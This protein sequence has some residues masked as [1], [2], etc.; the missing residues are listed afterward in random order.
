MNYSF[1]ELLVW[2]LTFN[3]SEI[4]IKMVKQSNLWSWT[5]ELYSLSI[6]KLPLGFSFE[7]KTFFV[8][9]NVSHTDVLSLY[10]TT[11]ANWCVERYIWVM[12]SFVPN[13]IFNNKKKLKGKTK[14]IW[15][16]RKEPKSFDIFF[17]IIFGCNDQSRISRKKSRH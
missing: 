15:Q 17:S 11:K 4:P 1:L 12:S 5:T 6:F 7:E 8:I 9:G 2:H 10:F 14:E 13:I 3:I 16:K